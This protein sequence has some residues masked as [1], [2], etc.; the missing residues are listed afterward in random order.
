[1]MTTDPYERVKNENLMMKWKTKPYNHQTDA[2]NK[3]YKKEGSALFMEQGTGKSKVAIDIACNLFME[4]KIN[5]VLLIAPNGVQTQWAEEQIPIHSSVNNFIKIWKSGGGRL[6]KRLLDEFIQEPANRLKWFCT[7][8]DVFSTLTHINKFLE[9][10]M[11][12]N[13]YVIV[14]E[15]T[16]I[17]NH[18]A[19]RTYNICYMLGRYKKARKRIIKVLPLSKYRSILTGTIVTNSP[20]DLWS[21]FEFL[22]HNYFDCN[23][24]AF[25]A[26][27]GIEIKDVHPGTGRM[28]NRGI[29][30]SE[31]QSILRYHSE[32][33]EPENISFMMGTS[34]SS[35][36]YIISHPKLTIPY[37]NLEE[38]KKKIEPIS[39][40]VRKDECLDLP[41]KIYEQLYVEMNTEQKRIYKELK[42][43][44]LSEYNNKELTVLN[45]VSLIG[46]LQQI[47]G[48]FFPYKDDADNRKIIPIT[49]SNPKIKRLKEDLEEAGDEIVIIW[50]RFVAELKML[51]TELMK[52]FPYK[53]IELYYGGTHQYTRKKI[54]ERFKK[55]EVDILIA[56]PRTAGIG[57]NLQRSS[58][59]YYFSNSYSLEDRVQSE[60]RLHRIGITK[61]VL[62][63]DIIIKGTVDEKVHEVLKRKK[64]LLDYFRDKS[65]KEF[66]GE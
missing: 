14:D 59:A 47:T 42:N 46:R 52:T 58:F 45:K 21:M 63:K 55:G 3:L 61:P 25:K 40:I 8:V 5:A 24:F 29:K 30:P 50:A 17:K 65:L 27:Y 16:R 26:R 48:G 38:L 11:H 31:I 6:Y 64:D 4:K 37:K 41:P 33:K 34:L 43:K 23:F 35:V 9:Y 32:G 15:S 62:Y 18:K 60:D 1:M 13:V 22:H 7:N 28:Y 20:Y 66:I 51:H 56:N 12:N 53:V 54:I 19:N 39:F 49:N 36:Q 57:L 44:L 10:L 2:Y